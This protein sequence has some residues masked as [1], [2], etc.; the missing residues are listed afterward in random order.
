[1]LQR[2][3]IFIL[4]LY[5]GGAAVS[6]IDEITDFF[7]KRALSKRRYSVLQRLFIPVLSLYYGGAVVSRIDEITGLFC[8]RAL[9]KRLYSVLQRLFILVL[10]LYYGVASVSRIDEIL[11]LFCK[12][13]YQRDCILCSSDVSF[14]YWVYTKESRRTTSHPYM[15]SWLL[16]WL[17]VYGCAVVWGDYGVASI[18]RLLQIT[19]LF[20]RI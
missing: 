16:K 4:G 2:L 6:R 11:G 17:I 1:M 5:Y 7:C 13:P 12:R 3:S 20:C 19:G 18:S 8:K 9:P 10:S 14:L 15:R